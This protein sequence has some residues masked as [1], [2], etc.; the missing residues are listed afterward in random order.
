[1][2]KYSQKKR[3]HKKSSSP[4]MWIVIACCI[5]LPVAVIAISWI[6][7]NQ[8]AAPATP[9]T[10][11]APN[12]PTVL[13]PTFPTVPDT[14]TQPNEVT[15]EYPYL[16]ENLSIEHIGA[17]SGIYM[18]DGT[19]D[20]VSNVL[21]ITVK[22]TGTQDLQLAHIELQ[23]TNFTAFFQATNLPAGETVVLLDTNRQGYV[24]ELPKYGLVNDMVFF[25][26]PMSLQ[27]DLIRV[28]GGNG[29]VE[30][31]N[32]SGADINGTIIIYYK[33]STSDV[34]YGGITY[35][36]RITNGI[37]AGQ[38]VR[39]MSRHYHPDRCSIIMVT[40]SE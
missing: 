2:G 29:Y 27:E 13:V 26:E 30:V 3:K 9:T 12:T 7:Q 6:L 28:S 11:T 22:N 14:P 19:D 31:T 4:V 39:V 24:E 40:C 15:V 33:N 37:P 5:A 18:E 35:R 1:M 36:V 32:I 17:Y 10:T 25:P 21:M 34:L 38:T 8:P 23:Y 20:T 16:N